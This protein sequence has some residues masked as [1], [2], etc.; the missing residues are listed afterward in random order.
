MQKQP[1]ATQFAR[2]LLASASTG[3]R[4]IMRPIPT[5]AMATALL[6]AVAAYVN[7][8][9]GYIS[10][11]E[12]TILTALVQHL[13]QQSGEPELSIWKRV[14]ARTGASNALT[15]R[16]WYYQDALNMMAEEIVAQEQSRKAGP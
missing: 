2:D 14:A 16:E 5:I 13:S 1:S 11:R 12:Q 4:R 10:A 15:I 8:E 9:A 3:K 6:V 7:S